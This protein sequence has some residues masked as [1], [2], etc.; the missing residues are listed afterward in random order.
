MIEI[1]YKYHFY[2]EFHFASFE[3][4]KLTLYDEFWWKR[5]QTIL[6]ETFIL[7]HSQECNYR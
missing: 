1:I 4:E 3:K 2:G 7:D 5:N 6:N